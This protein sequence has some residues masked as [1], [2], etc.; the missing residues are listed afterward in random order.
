M[1]R[2]YGQRVA[3]T[4]AAASNRNDDRFHRLARVI[5]SNSTNGFGATFRCVFDDVVARTVL[6]EKRN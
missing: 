2:N 3:L 5:S 1:T 4:T 6:V